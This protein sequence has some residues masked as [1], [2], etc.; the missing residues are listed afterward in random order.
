MLRNNAIHEALYSGEPLGF[1]LHGVG[2]NQ[3]L[4]VEMQALVCRLLI[5]LIGAPAAGYVKT[6]VDTYQY[7]GL[8][9]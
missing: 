9:L 2:A 4:T 5:A 8:D 1:G 7:H 3:N 6:Q